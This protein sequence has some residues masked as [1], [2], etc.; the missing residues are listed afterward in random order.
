VTGLLVKNYGI[1][2]A[3]KLSG[4]SEY[5]LRAWERRYSII[6]PFR[7]ESNRRLYSEYD[8]NK[9]KLLR[10]LTE[11]GIQ[12]S[13]LSSLSINDLKGLL[14]RVDSEI[15]STDE[16]YLQLYD[17]ASVDKTINDSLEAIKNFN[18]KKLLLILHRVYKKSNFLEFVENVLFPVM[19]K[20]GYQ[21]KSGLLRIAHEHFTSA[22]IVKFVLKISSEFEIKN[23][24]PKIVITS[25]DG[26]HHDFG[27]I[28]GDSLAAS[29]GWKSTYLG[30]SLSAEDIATAVNQTNSHC[31]FLSIIY[32]NDNPRM[33]A[34]LLELSKSIHD[35][36]VIIAGGNAVTGYKDILTNINAHIVKTPKHFRD[37]LKSIRNQI[38]IDKREN[39]EKK[40]L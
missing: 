39:Y 8:I 33:E 13:N 24:A 32:P 1:K 6:I 38:R 40:Y 26:Q 27:A 28:I 14:N 21:W 10:K 30:V 36:V 17:I 7:S 12:I 23:K 22:V 11:R 29:E 9:L 34:Q 2:K 31:I 16:K 35:D 15:I 4:V 20:I 5:T 37:T 3:A 25:P 19:V 18:E